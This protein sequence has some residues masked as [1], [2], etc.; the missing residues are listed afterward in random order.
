MKQ[1]SIDW[2][3]FPLMLIV[4]ACAV[5]LGCGDKASSQAQKFD[6]VINNRSLNLDPAILR[7]EQNDSVTINIKT[8]EHGMFHLH[9]YDME[10]EVN[11]EHTATLVFVANATGGFP[12]TFHPGGES[13]DSH[14]ETGATN[15]K[16]HGAL[17]ESEAIHKDGKF[18]FVV[19]D[20]EVGQ[21]I[22]YHNHMDHS[23]EGS[24][25]VSHTA[26]IQN[27]VEIQA[28]EYAFTPTIV[29][30]RPG[31]TIIW[32]NTISSRM[33]ITSG[34][35]PGQ[36]HHGHQETVEVKLGSLEVRPK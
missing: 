27:T 18:S 25:S 33:R 19:T 3:Y 9:G 36:H 21:N 10:F 16:A 30:V 5:F 15:L 20:A 32:I 23:M 29:T 28:N 22:P 12:I 35:P 14:G 11:P 7:V 24:I 26:P 2:R 4:T 8:S 6:L 13:E 17:F 34:K 1:P 31:T